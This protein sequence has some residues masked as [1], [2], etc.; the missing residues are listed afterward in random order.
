MANTY[1]LPEVGAVLCS[2]TLSHAGGDN[3]A[4]SAITER[5]IYNWGVHFVALSLT[6]CTTKC[7]TLH[8][9]PCQLIH[10]KKIIQ[11][12]WVI[13]QF[14]KL[15]PLLLGNRKGQGSKMIQF[16]IHHNYLW[17]LLIGIKKMLTYEAEAKWA[18]FRRR[19]FQMHFLEWKPCF[20]KKIHGPVFQ[21]VQL[22]ICHHWL[23]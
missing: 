13:I 8:S 12:N 19:N 22:V 9:Y 5:A 20:Y 14:N 18:P 15:L 3:G 4:S 7:Q 21:E 2:V 1:G 16:T 17:K 23:R 11:G 6:V 10:M